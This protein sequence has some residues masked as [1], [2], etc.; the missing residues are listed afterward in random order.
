MVSKVATPRRGAF[1]LRSR[2]AKAWL[3]SVQRS[4]VACASAIARIVVRECWKSC[5]AATRCAAHSRPWSPPRARTRSHE[6]NDR[7]ARRHDSEWPGSRRGW[8][9]P[10]GRRTDAEL[11]RSSASNGTLRMSRKQLTHR[12]SRPRDGR[13]DSRC[14]TLMT[15]EGTVIRARHA[16]LEP[17]WVGLLSRAD[18]GTRGAAAA[19]AGPAR[20]LRLPEPLSS[21]QSTASR[22]ASTCVPRSRP[23]ARAGGRAPD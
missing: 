21:R 17:R 10:H 14:S 1:E 8:P 19:R 11:T 20:H 7:S 2:P 9:W 22:R 18:A 3:S 6:E 23:R 13:L 16:T 4:S 5:G 15:A 12:G